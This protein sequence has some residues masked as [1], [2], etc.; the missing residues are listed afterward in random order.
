MASAQVNE[1]SVPHA[2]WAGWGAWTGWRLWL[3]LGVLWMA[4]LPLRPLFDPDE[5]RYAEIPREMLASGD[6]VTPRL[7]G[8]KY[9]E[10]P[11]LQ[12]WA[13]A[14]TYAAVGASEGASRFWAA[15]LAFLTLPMLALFARRSGLGETVAWRAA[16]MLAVSPYFVALGHINLLDQAFTFFCCAAVFGFVL[17]QLAP[18]ASI[19]ERRW[20]WLTWIAL[21]LAVLSKGI[22]ILVLAGGTLALYLLLAGHVTPLR[23]MHFRSGVPLFLLVAAPWFLLVQQRNPEFAAFFFVHE[24]FSRFLTEVHKRNEPFWFF[25]PILL[26]ALAPLLG[27]LKSAL[28]AAWRDAASAPQAFRARRFLLLW[29]LVTVVF[30]SISDSK[31]PPYILPVLPPLAL[32][33]AVVS[34]DDLRTARHA[35]WVTAGLLGVFAIGLVIYDLRRNGTVDPGLGGWAAFAVGAAL[36][37]PLGAFWRHRRAQPAAGTLQVV[38]C[39]APAA[40]ACILGWQALIAAYAQLPPARSATAVVAQV[41]GAIGPDTALFAVDQYRHS[42]SFYLAR[43]FRVVG[44]K[45]ELEFGLDHE[46]PGYIADL[47]TFA[48]VWATSGDAVAFIDPAA[49]QQ[50]RSAGLPGR[51]LADDQRSV[52]VSRR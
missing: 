46:N 48:R 30:F 44:Y 10:K 36:L 7:N 40:L 42:A 22:V 15:A 39:W 35:G 26:L 27:S 41:R 8:L 32:L 47:Q 6:W 25:I 28:V 12:Y 24:H 3:L 13:T 2:G 19:R 21:A 17:A 1:P 38:A 33:L 29:C 31:L 43:S 9:F 37:I 14:A 23:R 51:V 5:G 16:L 18:E 4:L 45:G 49:Y 52:V 34:T 50:L 11:P 20:M